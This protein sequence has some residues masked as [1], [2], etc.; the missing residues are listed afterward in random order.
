MD[1]QVFAVV[2]AAGSGSRFGAT[3]QLAKFRQGSLVT[4]ACRLAEAVCGPRTLLVT[5]ADHLAILAEQP[6]GSGFIVHNEEFASGLASSIA[7]GIKAVAPI[8]DYA[9]LLLADQP[10]ITAEHLDELINAAKSHSN[11]IAATAFGNNVGPPVI[12]PQDC[13]TELMQLQGDQGARQLLQKH[14][15]RVQTLRFD[16]AS[17]DIDRPQDL[18]GLH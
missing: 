4:N 6:Q 13:F 10:L 8:A 9:L 2:L 7:C 17:I 5:G 18:A 15:G 12:F 11:A 1:S 3:K 16:D 14:S